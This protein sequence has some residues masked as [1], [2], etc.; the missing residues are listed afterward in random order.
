[1]SFARK[2]ILALQDVQTFEKLASRARVV[3]FFNTV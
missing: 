2:D 1:M 3:L